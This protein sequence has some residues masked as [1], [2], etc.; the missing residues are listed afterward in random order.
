[1][2]HT[3]TGILDN[4]I[5]GNRKDAIRMISTFNKRRVFEFA[6]FA[7]RELPD[8]DMETMSTI[9]FDLQNKGDIR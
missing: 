9:W 4:W 2:E 3:F 1:M 8:D 6:V 5:N 7:S